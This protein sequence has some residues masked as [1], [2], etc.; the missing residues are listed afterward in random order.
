MERIKTTIIF[1]LI[2]A[3]VTLL[4]I[5]FSAIT[6]IK[7]N[8]TKM[9]DG[10]TVMKNQLDGMSDKYSEILTKLEHRP[11]DTFV[12]IRPPERKYKVKKKQKVKHPICLSPLTT[13]NHMFNLK[14]THQSI[15]SLI[16]RSFQSISKSPTNLSFD[17]DE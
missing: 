8:Q 10:Q 14:L 16:A 7:N 4:M 17:E 13:A 15:E 3:L 1:M 12:I 5:N 11:K 2:S 9:I 6:E